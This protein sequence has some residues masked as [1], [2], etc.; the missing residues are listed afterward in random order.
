MNTVLPTKG[1]AFDRDETCSGLK[2]KLKL[3]AEEFVILHII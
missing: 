3:I 2:L 1:L